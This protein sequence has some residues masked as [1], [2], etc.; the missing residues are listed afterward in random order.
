M[1]D[2]VFGF[3]WCCI[4]GFV[5]LLPLWYGSEV[6]WPLLAV[7]VL[8]ALIAA[9]APRVLALPNRLW[10]RFGKFM[11]G[12]TSAVALFLIYFLFFTPGA[13]LLRLFGRRQLSRH[14]DP[15]ARTYWAER[16]KGDVDFTRPY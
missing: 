16:P 13:A 8:L 11:H 1:S 3:A 10:T 6:R 2:R 7:A 14:F 4:V 9:A 12:V 5:A 15:D